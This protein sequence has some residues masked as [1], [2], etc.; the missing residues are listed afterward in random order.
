MFIRILTSF[1]WSRC[2]VQAEVMLVVPEPWLNDAEL[3]VLWGPD[4][5]AFLDFSDKVEM[6][7]GEGEANRLDNRFPASCFVRRVC[8]PLRGVFLLYFNILY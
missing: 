1:G 5:R 8:E 3:E 6:L 4:R 2:A 7:G